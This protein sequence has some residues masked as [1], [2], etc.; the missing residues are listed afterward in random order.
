MNLILYNNKCSKFV[1]EVIFKRF[2]LF[3]TINA[4]I[5]EYSSYVCPIKEFRHLEQDFNPELLRLVDILPSFS[6]CVCVCVCV[7]WGSVMFL[8]N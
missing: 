8:L 2:V 4:V 5:F 7:C 1:I 3:L 6:Q